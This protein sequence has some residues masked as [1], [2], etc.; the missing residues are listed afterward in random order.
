M[1]YALFFSP[2]AI[3]T[4]WLQ[5]CRWL[6]RD[7]V[8]GVS[9]AQPAFRGL[10]AETLIELTRTPARYGFH[11][12]IMAPF[13]LKEGLGE[14]DLYDAVTDFTACQRQLT[15]PPVTV[16]QL[17]HFF[18]LRPVRHSAALQGLASLCTRAFDRFRA[19]LHPSE[20][21]RRK[22][23]ELT[24]QEKKN[25]ELWGDP[26]VFEQFRFHFTLTSRMAEGKCKDRVHTAL[27]E[28]FEPLLD[29]PL[30]IDALSLFVEPAPGQPMRCVHRFSLATPTPPTE[31]RVAHDQQ[32]LPQNFYPGYQC[33]SS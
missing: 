19:P 29:D 20:L 1:R 8:S 14:Q 27:L 24:G 25:L 32:L 9:L 28:F 7:A 6:G 26:Y 2:P 30:L 3:S 12:T 23:A 31:E 18:C 5:G 22:A 10:D 4:L 16:S 13:R 15:I 21:A 17:D 11:A 33:Y